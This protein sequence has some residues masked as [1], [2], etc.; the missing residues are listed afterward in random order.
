MKNFLI[1]GENTD[2]AEDLLASAAEKLDRLFF[3][4]KITGMKAQLNFL[5]KTL[6]ESLEENVQLE[7][8]WKGQ[9]MPTN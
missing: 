1:F 5:E 3:Q 6:S 8:S 7:K 9:K 2:L 4:Q